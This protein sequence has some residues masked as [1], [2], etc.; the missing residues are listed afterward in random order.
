MKNKE[1]LKSL[2]D[3]HRRMRRNKEGVSAAVGMM[4]VVIIFII[5]LSIITQYYVPIWMTDKES[6]QMKDVENDFSQL[7]LNI[8]LQILSGNKYFPLNTP[9]SLGTEGI[10]IFAI[11][12][13]GTLSL[14]TR[15]GEFNIHNEN[16]TIEYSSVGS[17]KY[18]SNNRYYPPQNYIY[19][20]GAVILQQPTGGVIRISSGIRIEKIENNISFWFTMITLQ[21]ENR[22]IGGTSTEGIQTTLIE[23]LTIVEN[24]QN[25]DN[26][27]IQINSDYAE[28]WEKHF[29]GIFENAVKR[30]LLMSN[31]Y[32]I[33]KAGNSLTVVIY[34]VNTLYLTYAVV[35]TNIALGY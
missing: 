31:D 26:I 18:E 35:Y 11:G 22:T 12:T 34:G 32:F 20:N 27:T 25:G 1:N 21:G 30:G 8:D 24:W 9:I 33:A 23:N 5:I 3:C 13:S 17:L 29:N 2:E 19:E 28:I 15:K 4:L 14:D 10:P 7:K 6:K 16:R